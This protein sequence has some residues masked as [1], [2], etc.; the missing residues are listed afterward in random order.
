MAA[1]IDRPTL[2]KRPVLEAKQFIAI[3]FSEKRF[4]DF[5]GKL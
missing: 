2:V 4:S 5:R 3:G 1:M